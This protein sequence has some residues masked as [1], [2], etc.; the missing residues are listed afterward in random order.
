VKKTLIIG[1]SGFIGSFLIKELDLKKSINFD[2]KQSPFFPEIT[3]LGNILDEEKLDKSFK[4]VDSVILL[5][6]EHKD[7][8]SPINLYYDVNVNGTKNVLKAMDKHKVKKL[9]FTS[10]VAVY[11]LNK[12]NPDENF[13]VDPFNHYGKSKWQAENEIKLW[14]KNNNDKSITIIRPTVVFGE[15]NRGNVYN[16]LKQIVLKRFVMIGDGKNKKS[17]AYVRNL[18]SFLKIC[19]KKNKKGLNIFNYVDK[20]DLT[21]IKLVNLI[22]ENMGYKKNNFKIPFLIGF[23][24]GYVFDFISIITNSKLPISS[25]RIKKFCS[26]TE[27]SSSKLDL[28]FK[29]P[30]TIYEG[31]KK[32]IKYEFIDKNEIDITF[33]SE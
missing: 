1:G 33:E 29:P 28:I 18:V 24:I 10:S 31:L 30:Y 15:R 11:G 8:V 9:I 27:F 6:A 5:A 13:E 7:D 17:M 32:T 19:N 21:M 26:R 3:I 14:Y 23:F 16:L 22:R 20:P 2:K 4:D 12:D 25:V